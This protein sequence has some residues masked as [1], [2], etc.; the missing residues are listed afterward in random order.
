MGHLTFIG[1]VHPFDGKSLSKD[2]PI[3]D[4]L[5]GK[6]L[7]FLLSQSIGAPSKPC[8]SVGDHV[9]EGQKIA[10]AGGFV[11]A[12]LHS[13]VS[14]TVKSFEKRKNA[15]GEL[16][17]AIIVENDGKYEEVQYIQIIFSRI[18]ITRS[19]GMDMDTSCATA[20]RSKSS[21]IFNTRN[22]RPF[23]SV[24]LTK[25][26]DHVSFGLSGATRGC[27]TLAGSRFFS[28]TRLL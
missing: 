10:A 22:L 14:G 21:N 8:V 6:E 7:V 19:L 9:L 4:V 20:D 2:K 23:S 16:A 25:S 28:F 13:S 12:N 1:G 27:L 5:P 15:L 24:S 17:D 3:T 11:S 26:R 18:R